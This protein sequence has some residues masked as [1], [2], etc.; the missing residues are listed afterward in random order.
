MNSKNENDLQEKEK[1]NKISEDNNRNNDKNKINDDTSLLNKKTKPDE[2][3]ILNEEL[4]QDKNKKK[5]LEEEKSPIKT[6]VYEYGYTIQFLEN[7]EMGLMD[8]F[9]PKNSDGSDFYNY[10][11]NKEKFEKMVHDS[12]LYHYEK[13]LKEEKEKRDKMNMF[14]FNMN[15]NMN[16][17]S[18][19]N[20]FMQRG[21]TTPMNYM[22]S[23]NNFLMNNMNYNN[24]INNDDNNNIINKNNTENKNE[25]M[26]DNDKKE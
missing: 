26:S 10:G 16:M 17:N 25:I 15:I 23:M 9:L 5:K 22:N 24:G 3:D 21:M 1:D 7:D 18:M 20:N 6:E 2:L 11:L 12:L 19:G 8:D 13:H 14:M 4:S